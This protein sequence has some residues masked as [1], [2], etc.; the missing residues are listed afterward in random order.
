MF[1]AVVGGPKQFEE[2]DKKQREL[3]T[4]VSGRIDDQRKAEFR[5]IN[6]R[7]KEELAQLKDKQQAE[8][9]VLAKRQAEESRQRAEAIKKNAE[10][11]ASRQLSFAKTLGGFRDAGREITASQSKLGRAFEN[12]RDKAGHEDLRSRLRRKMTEQREKEIRDNAQDI[13]KAKPS[14]TRDFNRAH[15]TEPDNVS[16]KNKNRG[17]DTYRALR[18]LADEVT[19]NR[20]K[21]GGRSLTKKP[22]KAPEF[23]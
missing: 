12:A 22:P 15:G 19:Q 9:E 6:A 18:D 10:R 13:S 3:R 5:K 14:P 2:L 4:K 21:G 17:K 8:T 20:N 16:K 11:E 7:Y 23:R 1:T